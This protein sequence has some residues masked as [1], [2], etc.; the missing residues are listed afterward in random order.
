MLDKTRGALIAGYWLGKSEDELLD[1]TPARLIDDIH[2]ANAIKKDY[3]EL[4]SDATENGML[5][6]MNE[7]AK[8]RDEQQ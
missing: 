2:K 5:K 3:F 8:A 6:G 1:E 4:M 7:I